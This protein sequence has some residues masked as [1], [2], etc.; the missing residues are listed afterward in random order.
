[1]LIQTFGFRLQ[2]IISKALPGFSGSKTCHQSL[3]YAWRNRPRSACEGVLWLLIEAHLEAEGQKP[4]GCHRWATAVAAAL[5]ANEQLPVGRRLGLQAAAGFL[6]EGQGQC[7]AGR[8]ELT[9]LGGM[10]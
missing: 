5:V 10:G 7:W 6:Q 9:V 3:L 4:R 2:A 1:M 8:G